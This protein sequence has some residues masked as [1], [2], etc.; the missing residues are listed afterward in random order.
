M[1]ALVSHA[2][3]FVGERQACEALAVSRAT[4]HRWKAPLC[5]CSSERAEFQPAGELP[6]HSAAR[7]RRNSRSAAEPKRMGLAPEKKRNQTQTSWLR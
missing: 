4:Y 6:I 1:I 3:T 5:R 2:A 7:T